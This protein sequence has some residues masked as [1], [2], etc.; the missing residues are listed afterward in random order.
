M[1]FAG[2]LEGVAEAASGADEGTSDDTATAGT[3]L[4]P[5]EAVLLGESDAL[6][7]GRDGRGE[8]S[9]GETLLATEALT[10]TGALDGGM[11]FCTDAGGFS[12]AGVRL[13]RAESTKRRLSTTTLT[14][15]TC[16]AS[17]TVAV[18]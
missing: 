1:I 5:D 16:Q 14:P 18:R 3:T 15:S 7:S 6:V 8:L 11:V 12:T 13:W 2:A 4:A 9:I 10:I 17:R